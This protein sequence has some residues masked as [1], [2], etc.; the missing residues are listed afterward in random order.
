[1]TGSD[2]LGILLARAAD[3]SLAEVL[4]ERLFKPLGMKDTGFC[5]PADKLKRLAG[6]YGYDAAA[7]KLVCVDEGKDR[8]MEPAA[9]LRSREQRPR[10]DGRRLSSVA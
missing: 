5:V 8:T 6:A 7:S 3:R 10:L 1:M 4:Q 9:D 2:V